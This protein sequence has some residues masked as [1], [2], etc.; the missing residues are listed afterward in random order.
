MVYYINIIDLNYFNYFL[1][2]NLKIKKIETKLSSSKKDI[3]QMAQSQSKMIQEEY[4]EEEEQSNYQDKLVL[5]I[6]EIDSDTN[7]PDMRCFIMFDEIEKEYLL[8]G[9]RKDLFVSGKQYKFYCKK[10]KNVMNYFK[11]ILLATNNAKIILYNFNNLNIH[12]NDETEFK[13][14]QQY[15][16]DKKEIVG[17][18]GVNL[19]EVTSWN[20]IDMNLKNLKHIRY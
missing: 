7:V 18:D 2:I 14:L 16:N 12:Y 4:Y 15:I 11:T 9:V 6:E 13:Q 10:R 3:Q 17:Y 1:I 19:R 20:F 8:I 5:Y